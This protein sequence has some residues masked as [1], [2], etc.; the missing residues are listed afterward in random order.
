VEDVC[1]FQIQRLSLLGIEISISP[2]EIPLALVDPHQIGLVLLNLIRNAGDA[3]EE[4]GR[5][6]RIRIATRHG[7]G[8]FRLVVED[9]GPGIPEEIRD[10]VFRHYFTTKP[11]GKG[12]GLGLAVCRRIVAAHGGRIGLAP[13]SGRGARFLIDLPV[14]ACDAEEEG[15]RRLSRPDRPLRILV[16]D[17]E[18]GVRDYFASVLEEDGH[19]VSAASSGAEA[20]ALAAEREFDIAFVDMQ[21]PGMSGED[22]ARGLDRSRPG[23]GEGIVM[24]SGDFQPDTDG[25]EV[26]GK[27]VS[28]EEILHSASRAMRRRVATL[29]PSP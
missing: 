11:S 17:D 9:D 7:H 5:P 10:R 2:G 13:D 6:G 21:M 8:S 14:P 4:T 20:M 18:E 1:A 16:V 23:L 26:L 19:H 27:P 24:M 25:P 15:A 12:T 22:C 3:I 29:S 28:P